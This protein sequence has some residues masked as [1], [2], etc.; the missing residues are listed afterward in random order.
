MAYFWLFQFF[1]FF[2][3]VNIFL[4]IL[5]DA[6]AGVKGDIEEKKEDREREAEELREAILRG[7][8]E[9]AKKLTKREQLRELHRVARG[10]FHR[11]QSRVK[12]MSLRRRKAPPMG[13]SDFE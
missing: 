8:V 6:Y 2:I 10:R 1:I 13:I 5:N 4:A 7:D 9:E 11:F 12:S 3:V